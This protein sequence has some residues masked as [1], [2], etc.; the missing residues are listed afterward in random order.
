M[1]KGKYHITNFFTFFK[2][3]L[4]RIEPPYLICLVLALLLNYLTT[5][6][7]VY[8]GPSFQI[9]HVQLFAHFGY[10]NNFIGKDWL[11]PV[12]WTLAIEFQF[13]LLMAILFPL[14]SSNKWYLYLPALFI[15]NCFGNQL[16][17]EYL[18]HFSA[19]FTIGIIIYRFLA[20][21][22]TLLE[23]I[24]LLL[25]ANTFVYYHFGMIEMW[26]CMLTCI[27]IF[28]PLKKNRIGIW[29]GN[30]SYSLYLLHFPIGL[31]VI[32]LTQ[33]FSTDDNI[34]ILM[35]L[36]AL[37]ISI[38]A[39]ALYFRIIENPFKQIAARISYKK[40]VDQ[41]LL[42]EVDYHPVKVNV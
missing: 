8:T 22:N 25:I 26:I 29:F 35:V 4:I 23:L 31:R 18:F 9:D 41:Q 2:K 28:L 19:Y 17:R 1:H 37:L 5:K 13:Y 10:L 6:S 33:R 20:K 3:R 32:N 40:P 38:L 36:I 12:F 42:T 11:N 16:G 15:F 21:K 7:P 27:V 34:R 30:I 39:A 14:I 24:I